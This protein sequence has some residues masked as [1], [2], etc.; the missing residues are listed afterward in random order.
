MSIIVCVLGIYLGIM[1]IS[2][3]IGIAYL[4]GA[5]LFWSFTIGLIYQYLT[6]GFKNVKRKRIIRKLKNY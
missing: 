2:G 4:V 6:G 3:L 1:A 5:V